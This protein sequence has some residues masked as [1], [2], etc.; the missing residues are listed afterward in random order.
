MVFN[1]CGAGIVFQAKL[2]VM[3]GTSKPDDGR[4]RRSVGVMLVV[5]I[6][7]NMIIF[8]LQSCSVCWLRVLAANDVF[9]DL[10]PMNIWFK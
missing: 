6:A 5:A 1:C 10:S 4:R 8:D 7:A 9:V 3:D 2:F